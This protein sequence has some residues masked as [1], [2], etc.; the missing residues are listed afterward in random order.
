MRTV[1]PVI[2]AAVKMRYQA[3]GRS[4]RLHH[5]PMNTHAYSRGWRVT[6]QVTLVL[7]LKEKIRQHFARSG[8]STSKAVLP[9][10]AARRAVKLPSGRAVISA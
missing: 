3:Q 7:T 8:R 2:T 4:P 10:Y 5:L 9:A 6:S 1:K